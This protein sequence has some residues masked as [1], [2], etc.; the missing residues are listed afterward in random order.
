M[1]LI[2]S[3]S[4]IAELLSFDDY[5]EAVSNALKLHAEDQ[6]IQPG[7]L[8]ADAERGE[9]HIKTGGF[10]GEK[11][12]FGLKANGGFFENPQ[13]HDL[14]SILG[15]IY[16]ADGDN[17]KPLA[18]VD[19]I[20]I[21]I[22]RTA[23]ATAVAAKYLANSDSEVATVCG[24]GTQAI[25]QLKGLKSV[26]PIRQVYVHGRN[27]EKVYSF[28]KHAAS[29]LDMEVIPAPTLEE[30]LEQSQVC[31][32][33]TP[34]TEYFIADQFVKPGT[35]IAAVGADSPGKQELEPKLLTRSK[36]Y[37]DI[38]EQSVRVGEA[39]HPI[40]EGLMKAEDLAGELGAVIAG[41]IPGRVDAKEITIFDSTGTALQDVAVAFKAYEKA[42][43]TGIGLKT[44]L[45]K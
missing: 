18:I 22:N 11:P 24:Y 21:S 45:D 43:L 16:L 5:I 41:Q 13:S 32:T 7:L 37:A 34:S 25:V 33:C 1:T 9:F 30:A 31:V 10:K 28:C 20:E 4:E 17:G 14:P 15:V 23:A 39:Q 27:S 36:V 8:H 44:A 26:L 42:Q 29:E 3:R 6:T 38:M 12:V 40:N 2:L 19:S 35:F